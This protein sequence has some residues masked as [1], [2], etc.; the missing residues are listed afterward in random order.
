MSMRLMGPFLIWNVPVIGSPDCNLNAIA[1]TAIG[2]YLRTQSNIGKR[3]IANGITH[4]EQVNQI[5][6]RLA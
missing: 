4:L 6:R 5:E 3:A 2:H 1:S